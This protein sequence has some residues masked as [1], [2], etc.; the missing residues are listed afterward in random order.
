MAMVRVREQAR[1]IF[2]TAAIL[3]GSAACASTPPAETT[4]A[5]P[6]TRAEAGPE[7]ELTNGRWYTGRGFEPRTYFSVNGVLSARRPA[8]VDSVIDLA[9]GYVI[10]PFGDAHTHNLDGPFNLDRIRDTYV[11]EGTVYV[12]VLTNSTT[13]AAAVRSRFNRPCEL[14]VAYANGGLTSTLSHPFLAYEPRAMQIQGEWA[15][16]AAEIRK[17]RLRENN[18]YWFLDNI[19]DVEAKWPK[20]L[21]ARP[22]VIKIFLLD[23]REDPPAMSDSGLP[24]GHGLRPSL[25]PELVRRA[26]AAGLRVAAHVETANDFAVAVRGGVDL[27]AHLPG[28]LMG[29]GTV[30]SAT[31]PPE[32][33]QISEEVAA[34]AG[35]RG[36]AFTPTLVWTKDANGPDSAAAVLHR[37]ELMVRNIR[38]LVS[39]GARPVVGSDRFGR[40]AL[41]EIE[42][43]RELGIWSDAE[44]VRLWAV[45]TPRSIFP[46]RRIGRLEPGYEASFLVLGA[47]PLEH[48]DAV[49]DIRLRVKQGCVMAFAS[50][51]P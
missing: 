40:T 39:K 12:Q 13:G 2:G 10:P 30:T 31:I 19:A 1:R 22:D 6:A 47:N 34:A 32:P 43:F 18:A 46:T 3:A 27:F 35:A 50:A 29:D 36:V 49:K 23:A 7:F 33:W 45:E 21:A 15:A 28:Y 44:L 37:R 25:V 17:S 41:P 11:R 9:G 51:S 42:A 16:H 38:L 26:H 14:D 48:F 20:I 4:D 24:S 5:G 8:T